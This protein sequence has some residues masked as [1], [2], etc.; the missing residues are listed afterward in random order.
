M[1]G[2]RTTCSQGILS[3]HLWHQARFSS[4]MLCP[5]H[6]ARVS[7]GQRRPRSPNEGGQRYFISQPGR[8]RPPKP[9]TRSPFELLRPSVFEGRLPAINQNG[10]PRLGKA[11]SRAA[12]LNIAAPPTRSGPRQRRTS[13][14]LPDPPVRWRRVVRQCQHHS[15]DDNIGDGHHRCF[16]AT[17][18]RAA[19]ADSPSGLRSRKTASI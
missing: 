10:L 11:G 18:S 13:L 9:V 1:R 7:Q 3:S 2:S 5:A 6:H 16:F 14:C 19:R 4:L 17:S 15:P 8:P 12:I